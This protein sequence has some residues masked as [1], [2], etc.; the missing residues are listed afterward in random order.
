MLEGKWPI[1]ACEYCRNHEQDG[2]DSD[3]MNQ[4]R[5]QTDTELNPPELSA[6]PLA[7]EVTPTMLEV[8]FRNTCNMSCVYCGPHL[9]SKWEQEIKKFGPMEQIKHHRDDVYNLDNINHNP[10]YEQHK[11]QFWDYLKQKD[12][13]KVI[14][15]FMFLG[16]EPMVIPELDES[17]DFWQN[18]PN[19]K[20][21]F[22]ITTNLKATPRRFDDLVLRI[23]DML[24]SGAVYRFKIVAS[25]DCL[26]PQQEYARHGMNL[27]NFFENFERLNSI[28]GV[29]MGV[30]SAIT[31]LTIHTMPDLLRKIEKWNSTR[32]KNDRII[33]SFNVDNGKTDPTIF[34]SGVFDEHLDEVSRLLP[35]KTLREISAKKHFDSL[36]KHICRS[37]KQPERIE[38]FKNYLSELDKRRNTDWKTLFPWLV[39]L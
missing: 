38:N 29:Q 23:H 34:G 7:V 18:N 15:Y 8:Y 1:N 35:Q 33:Y 27:G 16:G 3:R 10:K 20:L 5:Q 39:S 11:K 4:I 25:I 21:T 30:N 9:S 22:Q 26:G 28:P 24:D 12:R 37:K 6:N 14:R 31:A 17:L 19:N 2:G 36:S 13:Y 32:S